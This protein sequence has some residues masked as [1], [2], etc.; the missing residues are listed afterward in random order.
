M[1]ERLFRRPGPPRTVA[2]GTRRI[3]AGTATAAL[4]LAAGTLLAAPAPA[5]AAACTGSTG[6]TVVVDFTRVGGGITTACAPG[7]PTTGLAALRGAGFTPT[8]TR[9][10]GPAFVCRIDGLPTAAQ[11]ACVNTPPAS[12]YWSYWHAPRQG[13]WT[14]STLGA[15]SHDPAPDTV[16]G[17]SFG[18]GQEPGISPP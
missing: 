10:S 3:R 16:E 1:I 14:Y 4:A 7:N 18:S 17:W 5:R 9:R 15:A 2:P 6:V 12:A 11:D 8:G 13:T